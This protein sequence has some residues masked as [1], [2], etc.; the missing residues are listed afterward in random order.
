MNLV[1][2]IRAKHNLILKLLLVVLS[3]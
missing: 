3:S 1:S 2:F